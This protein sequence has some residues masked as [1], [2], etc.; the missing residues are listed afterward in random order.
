MLKLG[1][2]SLIDLSALLTGSFSNIGFT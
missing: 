1:S 2:N